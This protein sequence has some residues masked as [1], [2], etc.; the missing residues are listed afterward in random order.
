MVEIAGWLVLFGAAGIVYVVAQANNTWPWVRAFVVSLFLVVPLGIGWEWVLTKRAPA[1][2]RNAIL[3]GVL[4]WLLL[5]PLLMREGLDEFSPDVILKALLYAAIFIGALCAGYL[6]PAFSGVR[7]LFSRMPSETN[8]D[9]VFWLTVAIYA[10][11]IVPQIYVSGGSPTVF[12]R[13]LLAGYSPDVEVGWRR[14]MLGNLDDFLKSTARLLELAVPFLGVYLV[15]RQIVTWQKLV[16]L[17]MVLSLLLIIFFSGER[18]VFALIVLGPLLYVFF[19]TAK[20]T[21][22]KWTPAFLAGALLLFW[23]MQAQ[24][25]FRAA[26]FYEF[27]PAVV[28]TNPLEMH[29]DNNFYWFTTATDTMPSMYEFTNEWVFLQIFT[30]P[31]PRFLWPEKPYTVGLPFVQWDEV[32]ASLSIS[33]VGELYVSQG[34]PGIILGGLLYGW[35]AKNWDQLREYFSR[36]QAMNLVFALGVTLLLIG[37]RSFGDIVLN[38]YVLGILVVALRVSGRSVRSRRWEGIVTNHRL[39]SSGETI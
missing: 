32:G 19:V 20:A 23:M 29:R 7:R 1:N 12:W 39:R 38:W 37:V 14:G 27:D 30:H 26:G 2:S 36:N 15:R 8:D 25:Q 31:I 5:D 9:R 35:M 34:L 33:I 10:L 16:L 24:V 6:I 13:L 18:R 17:L 22:K 4:F 11:G 3:A 28:Q 21:R